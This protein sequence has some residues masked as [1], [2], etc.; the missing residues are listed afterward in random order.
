MKNHGK[1]W[2]VMKS[3]EVLL[4]E[5]H[6]RFIESFQCGRVP[7]QVESDGSQRS[8][9]KRQMKMWHIEAGAPRFEIFGSEIRIKTRILFEEFLSFQSHGK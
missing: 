3:H 9:M 4:T 8:N 7:L 5:C 2:N 6:K 1:S